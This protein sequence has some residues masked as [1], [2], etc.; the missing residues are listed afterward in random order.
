MDTIEQLQNRLAAGR[1][2]RFHT[3][4]EIPPQSLAERSFNVAL[5]ASFL[6]DRQQ[7]S[8][9]LSGVL[10][11]ALTHDLAEYYTCDM[12]SPLKRKFTTS[13][14]DCLY[15]DEGR[16]R[17]GIDPIH[18][19]CV[20]E[21]DRLEV[22]HYFCRCVREGNLAAKRYAV[23]THEDIKSSEKYSQNAKE[24]AD[25]FYGWGFDVEPRAANQE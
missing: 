12:P 21:A 2:A 11:N 23:L 22:L 5:I 16:D 10:L 19:R 25:E 9:S 7:S 4:V 14:F 1:V 6:F 20:L 3:A 8:S 13:E 18:H 15:E 17:L 24:L